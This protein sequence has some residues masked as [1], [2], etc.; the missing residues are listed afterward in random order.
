[1]PFPKYLSPTQLGMLVEKCAYQAELRYTLGP[2]RPVAAMIIGSA[3]DSGANRNFRQ[4]IESRKNVPLEAVETAAAE[5]FTARARSVGDWQDT[6]E[7]KAKDLTV[8][9]ARA[10]YHFF[11]VKT[12]PLLVQETVWL[13][14]ENG[15]KVKGILDLVDENRAVIDTKTSKDAYAEDAAM[16]SLQLAIYW[17]ALEADDRIP[18]HSKR[19]FHV[20]VKTAIPKAQ[21]VEAPAPTEDQQNRVLALIAAAQTMKQ[22]GIFPPNTGGWWCSPKWCGYWDICPYHL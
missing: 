21:L 12:Q 8:S 1:M 18:A 5:A 19:A 6:T 3:V 2:I 20:L 22:R 16:T 17:M 14:L 9:L 15:T 4:K 13:R 11:G 7:G 10:H